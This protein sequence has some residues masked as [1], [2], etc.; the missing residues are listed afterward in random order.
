MMKRRVEVEEVL[1]RVLEDHERHNDD[2]CRKC[3]EER[4]V[5]RFAR[6]VLDDEELP[7]LMH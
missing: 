7:V 4:A 3:W 5:I 6:W 1:K 2:G